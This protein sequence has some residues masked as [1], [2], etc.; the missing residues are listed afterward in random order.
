MASNFIFPKGSV[1]LKALAKAWPH[2]RRGARWALGN[3]FLARFWLD[4]WLNVPNPLINVVTGSVPAEQIHAPV[5]EY[6][7]EAGDW[8]WAK[9]EDLLPAT[10]LLLIAAVMPPRPS[11]RPDRLVWGYTP[12]GTFTTK[13][14]YEALTRMAKDHARPLWQ[15]IWRAPVAQRVRQFLWLASRDRL[16]TNMERVRRHMAGDVACYLCGQPESTSHVLRDCPH[17]RR[18]WTGIWER[19]KC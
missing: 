9:F 2:V 12:N 17:A 4:V 1:C 5:A 15:A 6:V 14:A 16:F 18:V 8:C 3:G 7:T 10:T 19:D 13:S 11:A